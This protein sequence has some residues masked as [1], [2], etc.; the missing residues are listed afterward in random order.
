MGEIGVARVL[1]P[2]LGVEVVQLGPDLL[3]L[4]FQGPARGR[5]SLG[6][7]EEGLEPVLLEGQT[8]F[9][10]AL[11]RRQR[12]VDAGAAGGAALGQHVEERTGVSVLARLEGGAVEALAGPGRREAHQDI[13]AQLVD[14][15]A[16][17]QE[18]GAELR[19][20]QPVAERFESRDGRF[21]VARRTFET[22]GLRLVPQ[23]AGPR[24][25]RH[26]LLDA[27]A[28]S[29]RSHEGLTEK[30]HGFRCTATCGQG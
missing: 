24:G 20:A 13:D 3:A 2:D 18:G 25:E 5:V 19:V 10:V 16:G 1:A 11:P 29:P 7:A 6:A 9:E 8:A 27:V 22:A 21:S 17:A 30:S 4:D 12:R 14:V 23:G 15:A 28:Y 26:G